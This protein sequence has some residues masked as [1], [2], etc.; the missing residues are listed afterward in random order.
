MMNLQAQIFE[1]IQ[2][3]W[4][5]RWYAIGIA[6]L[7]CL[8]GWF[9]VMRLPDV[10]SS[11]ARVYVDMDSMLR[12]L[13]KDITVDTDLI[14]Q[15][16]TV[17]KTMLSR[18]NLQEVARTADLDLAVRNEKEMEAL[19]NAL[20]EDIKLVAEG[21]DL[22]T[23]SYHHEDARKAQ[24]VVQALLTIF[25]EQ[26]LGESRDEME[27][28]RA[29][30]DQQI[31]AN[32]QRLRDAERKLAEFKAANIEVLQSPGGFSTAAA[33]AKRQ[34][35]DMNLNYQDALAVRDRLRSTLAETP[36][37]LE[38]NSP[39]GMII[40]GGNVSTPLE[41]LEQRIHEQARTLDDMLTRYTEQHPDV[42]SLRN[43]I[44]NL[45]EQYE[46]EKTREEL[47]RA[48]SGGTPAGKQ[49]VPNPLFEQLKLRMIEA[50][51]ELASKRRHLAAAERQAARLEE[52][53]FSALDV[54]AKMADYSR[55]YEVVKRNYEDLLRRREA[56][57]MTEA[58]DRS[59][60][61]KFRIID[62][63][64]VAMLPDGPPRKILLGAVLVVSLGAGLGFVFLLTQV[65]E[66]FNNASRLR[67]AFG[68]NVVGSV[69]G[70]ISKARRGRMRFELMGFVSVVLVLVIVCAG[71]VVGSA[72][73][74]QRLAKLDLQEVQSRLEQLI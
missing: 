25:V 12:P 67:E 54:E 23:I 40:R 19:L 28:A 63:P 5:R 68:F 62:P 34:I 45:Q 20:A 16:A 3:I 43:T 14:E 29:F 30:L 61:I 66:T 56:A 10:Y 71:L 8:V 35:E 31:A 11:Q 65:D 64:E 9:V 52:L 33:N 41:S 46:R 42:I 13:L 1:I 4:R 50:D 57:A 72:G 15:V 44:K 17:R 74:S 6:W 73:I 47:E 32:E 7:V 36:E 27:T 49:Q 53:A 51:A 21:K 59:T 38:V 24:A 58:V 2:G 26:N 70:V 48:S 39:A 69:S 55:D 60:S 22:V 18:A 37:Y